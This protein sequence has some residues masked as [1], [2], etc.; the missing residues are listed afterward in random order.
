MITGQ[1]MQ[2]LDKRA[3]EKY[4]IPS[5][6]LMENAALAF[7]NLAK[8]KDDVFCIVAGAGNNGGDGFAIGR[9]LYLLHK[10]V[11]VYFIGNAE[12][13]TPDCRTNAEILNRLGITIRAL[14]ETTIDDFKRDCQKSTVIDAIF[15]VGLSRPI[16]GF[17]A[18][19]IRTINTHAK[20]T[21]AVDIPSGLSADTGDVLGIAIQSKETITFHRM[22]IGMVQAQQFTG[23]ITIAY[24]GIPD[25]ERFGGSN[26]FRD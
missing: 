7:A 1:E 18:N 4:G 20:Y 21:M 22:K 19:V 11:I 9:H 13:M 5:I 25:D 12:K 2:A 8:D 14:N 15:G 23:H 16:E 26:E 10:E 6:A 17:Y 3:I 24:I